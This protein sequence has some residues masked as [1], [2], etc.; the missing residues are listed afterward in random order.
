MYKRF[1]WNSELRL[2]LG[3]FGR[4]SSWNPDAGPDRPSKIFTCSTMEIFHPDISGSW[5]D[6]IFNL[7]QDN[8]QHTFIILTKMPENI[9][10]PMP[11]NVWLGVSITAQ[12]DMKRIEGMFEALATTRFISFEPLLGPVDQ[13]T[14][15]LSGMKRDMLDWIIVG[16]MTGHGKK[17]DP[18]TEWLDEVVM[19]SRF[20][21]LPIFMK[22]NLHEIWGPNLIQEFPK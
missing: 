18:R 7:V 13:F 14:S 11:S 22:N 15:H 3:S 4:Y 2:N 12:A 17:Y 19:A 21:R 1:T 9:D 5:R 16:R 20:Y 8:P 6:D 10:R